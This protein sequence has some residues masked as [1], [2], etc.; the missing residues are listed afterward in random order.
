MTEPLVIAMPVR[1][2]MTRETR[3]ALAHN[4]GPHTLLTVTG[5]PV[6]EARNELAKRV[7][8]LE[9]L[10]EFVVWIDADA[11]WLPGA[12]ERLIEPLRHVPSLAMVAGY[13][14]RRTPNAP[15]V[16]NVRAGD[17]SSAVVLGRDCGE[18]DVRMI[19]ECGMHACAVRVSALRALGAHPFAVSMV[20]EDLAFCK[21]LRDQGFAIGCAAGITFAHVEAAGIAFVPNSGPLTIADGRPRAL[22]GDEFARRLQRAGIPVTFYDRG[23]GRLVARVDVQAAR[24]YGPA[25][26]ALVRSGTFA[27]QR[28]TESRA[29]SRSASSPSAETFARS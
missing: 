26:A 18:N 16:A 11:W 14:C 12:V 10:P 7:L 21:R 15:A 17:A 24:T 4:T 23:R 2:A 28:T 9:P 1:D 13:F 3:Q 6:D 5:K 19:A 25:S 27:R 20:G 8:S 29:T 22:T